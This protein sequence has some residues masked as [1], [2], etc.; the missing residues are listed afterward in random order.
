MI[1]HKDRPEGAVIQ[2]GWLVFPGLPQPLTVS[3]YGV[4]LFPAPVLTFIE[5]RKGPSNGGR[6]GY[7]AKYVFDPDHTV[8]EFAVRHM[9]VTWVHGQF[10]GVTGSIQFDPGDL[11]GLSAEAEIDVAGVYTGVAKRDDDLRSP[12]Y[13]DAP[14]FPKIAFKSTRSEPAGVDHCLLHGD[15][16]I[17]GISRPIIL[18]VTFAGPS[19]FQDDD[20]LYTTYGFK[21]ETRVNRED[22]GMTRNLELEAGGFMVGKHAYLTIN[23]EA[24]LA[25]E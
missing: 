16:T 20:R 2:G 5:S 7:M 10:N 12:N 6:G 21:G 25:E 13:F 4:L 19:R 22:F 17:R 15:L 9:M 18:D 3:F 14:R 11:A 24:D 1:L 8:A 23:I